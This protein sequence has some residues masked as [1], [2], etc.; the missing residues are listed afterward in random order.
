MGGRELDNSS[1]R[2]VARMTLFAET[3]NAR[4]HHDRIAAVKIISG[5][6]HEYFDRASFL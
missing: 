1:R 6:G 3:N 2:V 4:S 5:S